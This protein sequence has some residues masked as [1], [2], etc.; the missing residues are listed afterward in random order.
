[1][2]SLPPLDLSPI[3]LPEC[4][5]CGKPVDGIFSYEDPSTN[6]RV[7][8]ACCHGETEIVRLS[9]RDLIAANAGSL[10]LMRAFRED[11]A[12]SVV[13]SHLLGG[14]KV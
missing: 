8:A 14:W 13:A 11:P 12:D 6:E 2:I 4:A 9:E 1:M 7:I 3:D 5:K 10:R